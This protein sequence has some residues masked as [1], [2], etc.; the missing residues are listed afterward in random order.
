MDQISINV[1]HIIN[2]I[3]LQAPEKNNRYSR[4]KTSNDKRIFRSCYGYAT[5]SAQI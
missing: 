3:N 5:S 2:Y 1:Q 4:I